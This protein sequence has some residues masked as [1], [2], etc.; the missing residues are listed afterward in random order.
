MY[1]SCVYVCMQLCMYTDYTPTCTLHHTVHTVSALT[2]VIMHMCMTQLTCTHYNIVH[3]CTVHLSFPFHSFPGRSQTGWSRR[4]RGGWLGTARWT[5]RPWGTG[6][7][8][9]TH[10]QGTGWRWETSREHHQTGDHTW[11]QNAVTWI[12][13]R[14]IVLST[15]LTNLIENLCPNDSHSF[16]IRIYM[17]NK[18]K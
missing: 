17:H 5:G 13:I 9:A 14:C 6:S 4:D 2:Y 12:T 8:P 16:S 18:V 15:Q 10:T 1:T 3:G 11:I 7:S